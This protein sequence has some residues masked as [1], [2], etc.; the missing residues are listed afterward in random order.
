MPVK[1]DGLELGNIVLELLVMEGLRMSSRKA[2]TMRLSCLRP[3]E[4]SK[5]IGRENNK[6]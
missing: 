1:V 6:R 4:V 3:S 5:T 2:D